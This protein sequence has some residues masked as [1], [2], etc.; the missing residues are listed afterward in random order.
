MTQPILP[1]DKTFRMV[2]KLVS[3]DGIEL[4]FKGFVLVPE[5]RLVLLE[6][7]AAAARDLVAR[8]RGALQNVSQSTNVKPAVDVL[9]DRLSELEKVWDMPK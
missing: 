4:P 3:S 1:P 7:V 8:S 9:G 2:V 6:R 5:D